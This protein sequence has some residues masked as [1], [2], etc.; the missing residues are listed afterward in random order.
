MFGC[1][2]LVG[3]E[4]I[5]HAGDVL[6]RLAKE[7]KGAAPGVRLVPLHQGCPLGLGHSAGSGIGE[8]VDVDVLS[9]QVEYVVAGFLEELFSLLA[10]G[11]T[12]RLHHLDLERLRPS[13]FHGPQS[14]RTF[15]CSSVFPP[16]CFETPLGG[17]RG[18]DDS[19]G[20]AKGLLPR[21]T[22]KAIWPRTSPRHLRRASLSS[23]SPPGSGVGRRGSARS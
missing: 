1:P 12:N 20:F 18:I 7:L 2:S 23:W 10:R 19:F 13:G 21:I 5:R 3:G 17:S 9:A 22:C 11:E 16:R 14:Y 15:F 4:D 6:H 8:E